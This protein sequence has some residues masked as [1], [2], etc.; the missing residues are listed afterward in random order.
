M[1]GAAILVVS[2]TVLS[3]PASGFVALAPSL[4]AAR[5]TSHWSGRGVPMTAQ[6]SVVLDSPSLPALPRG[7]RV[8]RRKPARVAAPVVEVDITNAPVQRIRSNADYLEALR[9]NER[10]LV[11][12]KFFAPWCRSCKAMD[13]KY[14]KLAAQNQNVKFFEIDVNESP[15][16]KKALGVRSVPT[17]KLHAGS[18][19]QVANFTCGPRKVPELERKIGLCENVPALAARLSKGSGMMEMVAG[20]MDDNKQGVPARTSVESPRIMKGLMEKLARQERLSEAL[21]QQQLDSVP[22]ETTL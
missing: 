11:V 16:L 6:L 22:F 5:S 20:E 21:E 14:R 1:K 13:V 19:G 2:C 4:A 9:G 8:V 12:I 7:K 3:T 10:S 15:E 18:L 17:V